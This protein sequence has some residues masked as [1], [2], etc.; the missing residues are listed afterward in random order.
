MNNLLFL[1]LLIESYYCTIVYLD[2]LLC[3]FTNAV[4]NLAK[5]C[6]SERGQKSRHNIILVYVL[7]R[8][9]FV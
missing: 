3:Q 8:P 1:G 9:I 6:Y 2:C 5:A 7:K 4:V